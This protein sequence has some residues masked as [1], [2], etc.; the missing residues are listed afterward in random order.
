MEFFLSGTILITVVYVAIL[1]AAFYLYFKKGDKGYLLLGIS[2]FMVLFLFIPLFYLR[3]SRALE[4]IIALVAFVT[5]VIF[6][7]ATELYGT[8]L[9]GKRSLEKRDDIFSSLTKKE[10]ILIFATLFATLLSFSVIFSFVL[11][12]PVPLIFFLGSVVALGV[13]LIIRHYNKKENRD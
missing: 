1:V 7:I 4:V 10:K 2:F 13:Y 5:Y 6:E 3:E 9:R 11:R 8:D 12:E